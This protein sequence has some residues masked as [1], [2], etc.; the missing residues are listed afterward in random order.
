MARGGGVVEVMA[1]GGGVGEPWQWR[2]AGWGGGDGAA[3]RALVVV[4]VVVDLDPHALPS[5]LCLGM[6]QRACGLGEQSTWSQGT[7]PS[8]R[9]Y[10]GGC[11]QQCADH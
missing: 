4:A 2:R 7:D 3:P 10:R 6:E 1:C 8:V 9:N 11:S 5:F